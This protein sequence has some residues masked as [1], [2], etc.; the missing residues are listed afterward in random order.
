MI[1]FISVSWAEK[2][3]QL[4]SQRKLAVVMCFEAADEQLQVKSSC[5]HFGWLCYVCTYVCTSV[6]TCVR[7]YLF[8]INLPV[9]DSGPTSAVYDTTNCACVHRQ[10][11]A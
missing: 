11:D 1:A 5:N 10:L 9:S 2:N 3:V 8:K 6:R 4:L 7:T